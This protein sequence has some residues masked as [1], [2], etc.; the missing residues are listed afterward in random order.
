[1]YLLE[2]AFLFFFFFWIYTRNGIAR[3]YNSSIFQSLEKSPQC[4]PQW[5]HQFTFP[6]VVY[7]SSLFSTS[8]LTFV[9]C[10]LFEDSYS[11]RC[12][13]MSHCGFDLHRPDDQ[14]FR[15]SFKCLLAISMSSLEK[16]LFSSYHFLIRLF[17]F[18][19]EVELY[20]L[21]IYVGYQPQSYYLQIF[22]PIQQI[23]FLFN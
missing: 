3:S 11:D 5:L 14:R 13:V 19:S 16:C 18:F 21:F 9:I 2:L 1:M 8:L 7:R 6:P 17:A 4:F 22:S 15:A 10:V 20:Q 23:V 12:E